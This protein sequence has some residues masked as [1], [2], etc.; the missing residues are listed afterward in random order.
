LQIVDLQMAEIAQRL[1]EHTLEIELTDRARRALVAR[2]YDPEYGARPLRRTLQRNIESPLSRR[3]LG[4]EFATGDLIIVD[5]EIDGDP[6]DK[7]VLK[8]A[9]ITFRKGERAPIPVELPLSIDQHA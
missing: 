5:A 7:A 4:G 1:E 2:G 8:K 6:E 3:L 9:K